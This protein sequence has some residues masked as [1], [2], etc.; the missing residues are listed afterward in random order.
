MVITHVKIEPITQKTIENGFIQINKSKIIN[1]GLMENCPKEEQVI[2]LP[3]CTV[4]PGWIDG[5]SHL[6]VF[7]DGM[8][9]EGDDGNEDT[10]PIT[11]Q[12]R[13]LDAINPLDRG[14]SEALAAG[15][16]T[17][18]TGP[19]SANPIGGQ[20]CA[21][22]T[23]GCCVDDMVVKAPAAMKFAFGENPKTVYHGRSQA[24]VTRMATA[25]LIRESLKK[26]R[27]YQQDVELAAEDDD[28]DEPEYDIKCEALLP[29]LK[30]E[31]KVHIHAH[32]ADDICTALRICKEFQLDYVLVHCTEGYLI[33]D[34]LAKDKASV[35]CGPIISHRYKPELSQ[36]TMA[37]PGILAGKGI[38]VS[39]CTDHPEIPID[40]L[41][42]SAGLAV[43]EGMDYHKALESLTIVPARQCGIEDRVGSIEVGKD[44]DLVI[45]DQDPF[46]LAAK[47]KMV[48]INGEQVK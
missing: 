10:D 18:V 6:G 35:V 47:P 48:F 31:L 41:T 32:R 42:I 44:A 1:F 21:I 36:A 9:F 2:D 38:P 26:A 30:G 19:G 34:L 7:G 33:G 39:I 17:V 3:G 45:Y 25:A 16:T 28:V 37:N 24:P 4:Y 12:L 40:F 29:V 20:M 13:A 27:R 43:R 22:K 46:T 5:H 8:G 14:F 15:I 23:A 11:P